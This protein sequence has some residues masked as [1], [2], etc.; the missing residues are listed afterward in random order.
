MSKRRLHFGMMCQNNLFE[1]IPNLEKVLPYVDSVTLIDGGCFVKG[2]PVYTVEGP[3]PIEEITT[4][5]KVFGVK[6]SSVAVAAL[7]SKKYCGDLVALKPYNLAPIKMTSNHP[8]LILKGS[9]CGTKSRKASNIKCKPWCTCGYWED[10]EAVWV[11][12]D[13]VQEGDYL[14]VPSTFQREVGAELT[15]LVAELFGWYMAEGSSALANGTVSFS[16]NIKEKEEAVRIGFLLKSIYGLEPH[17]G[18]VGSKNERYVRVYS[19]KL[20]RFLK[21]IF[22]PSAVCKVV[23]PEVFKASDTAVM[24]FLRAWVAGDGSVHLKTGKEYHT[25]SLSTASIWA[26]YGAQQLFSYFRIVPSFSCEIREDRYSDKPIYKLALSRGETEVFLGQREPMSPTRRTC[27]GETKRQAMLTNQEL[28]SYQA[29]YF[30]YENFV[31]VPVRET[32]V[33]SFDGEVYNLETEDST[34]LTGFVVHNSTD[35]TIIYMRNW[36]NKEPKIKFYV[37]PWQD[38][39]P[40]QRNNYVR[41]ISEIAEP[42]DWELTADPDEVFDIQA[43]E[44]LHAAADRAERDGRNMIGFQCRSVSMAG[45]ERVHENLDDYWKQLFFKWDPNFHYTGYK[46]HEGKGGIPH[47]IMNTG[48]VYEHVKQENVIWLRGFRNMFHGGGG[49]NL[50]ATNPVWIKLRNL[51]R[52]KLGIDDWH[53]FYGYLLQGNINSGLKQIMIDHMHEGTPKA[54][55]N[56]R[57]KEHWDG[58]CFTPGQLIMTAAGARKLEEVGRACSVLNGSG[59]TTGVVSPMQKLYEGPVFT[60]KAV[61][62]VPVELTS[63]HPVLVAERPVCPRPGERWCR[64]DCGQSVPK[65]REDKRNSAW[66]G[67]YKNCSVVYDHGELKWVP[68][69]EVIPGKHCVVFPKSKISGVSN[70]SEAEA[71]LSGWYVADG[72]RNGSR[73][74]I[75]LHLGKDP[76]EDVKELFESTFVCSALI[77][78]RPEKNLCVVSCAVGGAE[79][80]HF[81]SRFGE[82]APVKHIPTEVFGWGRKNIA[83]FVRGAFKGDGCRTSKGN[84]YEV[85]TYST[86]SKVLAHELQFLLTKLDVFAGFTEKAPQDNRY[87]DKRSYVLTIEGLQLEKC[88]FMYKNLKCS[89][90]QYFY[91]DEDYFY[92]PVTS[93][94]ERFYKGPVYNIETVDNTYLAGFVVHNSEVREMYKTYFRILHLEEEPEEFRGEHIE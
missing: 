19:M 69:S 7:F 4:S 17:H 79:A 85:L 13:E 55:D 42:G 65:F 90:K 5:D 15:P 39:F 10:K 28:F 29:K 24:A 1:V 83:A 92:L 60:I 63:E 8:V 74:E 43:L 46:C 78:E 93:N 94:K 45:P 87:S 25:S 22:G 21:S 9:L 76:A 26:A 27:L 2:Q 72:N 64:P 56:A 54:G 36:S 6:G 23:P 66:S 77:T 12:A 71:E 16:L 11:R 20:A 89:S 40:A 61:N 73:I 82:R 57:Q 59:E 52:D 58:S 18:E 48:L 75:N 31:C 37:Y 41:H 81:C 38:D 30:C 14:L 86:A 47:L 88:G 49:P 68:A 51:C 80:E 70:V 34:Y 32:E 84:P 35:D 3:K 50:G 91:Q 53:S 62:S 67:V 33:L 44:K